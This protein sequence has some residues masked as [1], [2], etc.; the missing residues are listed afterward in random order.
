MKD[1]RNIPENFFSRKKSLTKVENRREKIR[2]F[3]ALLK[4]S[5]IQILQV[6][7]IEQRK[8]RVHRMKETV[9]ELLLQWKRQMKIDPHPGHPSIWLLTD[10]Y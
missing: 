3:Q 7:E 10:A 6:V 2:K 4:K 9:P 5:N 1:K 8:R